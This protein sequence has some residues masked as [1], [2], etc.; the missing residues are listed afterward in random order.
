[1][2]ML[3]AD[4][5]GDDDDRDDCDDGGKRWFSL[6]QILQLYT[7]LATQDFSNLSHRCQDKTFNQS[8]KGVKQTLLNSRYKRN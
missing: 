5:D 4:A 1:M 3:D 8:Q 6:H 2:T 7:V